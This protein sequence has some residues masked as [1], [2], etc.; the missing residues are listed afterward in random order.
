M[1]RPAR[2]TH[3]CSPHDATNARRVT[4]PHLPLP[5]APRTP[6]DLCT[7]ARLR[8]C[9][10]HLEK[11]CSRAAEEN[12]NPQHTLQRCLLSAL[13][14]APPVLTQGEL[15]DRS[16]CTE[17]YT[18]R[19]DAS[20][21]TPPRTPPHTTP[22]TPRVVLTPREKEW[23]AAYRAA[24]SAAVLTDAV[25]PPPNAFVSEAD[26]GC[27]PQTEPSASQPHAETDGSQPQM[28]AEGSR[29]QVEAEGS[30]P[31]A[32]GSGGQP[33]AEGSGSQPAAEESDSQRKPLSKHL[34][35][36][37]GCGARL[38]VDISNEQL[39]RHV[40]ECLNRGCEVLADA[41]RERVRSS[42]MQR[43]ALRLLEEREQERALREKDTDLTLRAIR[44]LEKHEKTLNDKDAQAYRPLAPSCRQRAVQPNLVVH[45]SLA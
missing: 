13:L 3:V 21:R 6:P 36:P 41:W 38:P 31:A 42:S 14:T 5:H 19:V 24:K 44:L 23:L 35:C 16:T 34:L 33:H 15:T 32:E 4:V 28:E 7:D 2:A 8:R 26:G 9:R 18:P 20:P 27:Q 12:P 1:Q 25:A 37:V 30:R 45:R 22:R 39:N 17:W 40:D 43:K 10:G 29:P 11:R